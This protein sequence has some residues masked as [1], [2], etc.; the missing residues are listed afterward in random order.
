MGILGGNDSYYTGRE[1]YRF[2]ERLIREGREILIVSPYIDEYYARFLSDNSGGKRIRIISSSMDQKARKLLGK[3]RPLG[4]LL[5]ALV[6]ILALDYLAYREGVFSA[7]L[8]LLS[9]AIFLLGL[10]VFASK[11]KD[12]EIRTP[13]E[14]V[15][16]KMYI[17]ER[18]AI[19]GSANLTYNGMHRNVEQIEMI[20]E[21]G[22]V[23][24]LREEFFRLWR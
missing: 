20:R 16:A 21:S 12:I 17:N 2:A 8:A 18:E 15:H 23:E 24:R 7:M 1:C 6:I 13:V 19:H 10:A 5:Y 4:A 14:F 22:K 3:G 11:K 9:A